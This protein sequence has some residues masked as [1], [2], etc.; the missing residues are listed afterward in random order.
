[1]ARRLQKVGDVV[2]RL[3]WYDVGS[4]APLR[5]AGAGAPGGGTLCAS[6]FG[7]RVHPVSLP[8]PVDKHPQF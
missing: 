8:V 7:D 6:M 1:M 4:M 5:T 2:W 3:V